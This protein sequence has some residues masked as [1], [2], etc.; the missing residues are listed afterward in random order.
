MGQEHGL[1]AL[2]MRVTRNLDLP[3]SFGEIKQRRLRV[4]QATAHIV[5]R[6]SEPESQIG[7]YLVIAAAS[8]VKLASSVARHFEKMRLDESVNV[9]LWPFI[10]I[11]GISLSM[12]E[13][14]SQC[15]CDCY[16]F[17]IGQHS[18]AEQSVAMSD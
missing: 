14:D 5:N 8:C 17:V 2:Q 3:I 4:A 18:G 15:L 7:G 11:L 10:K 9:F 16:R 12:L 13:Y 1:S 6:L